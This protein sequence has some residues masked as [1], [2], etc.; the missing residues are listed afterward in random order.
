MWGEIVEHDDVPWPQPLKDFP[1][2]IVNITISAIQG[3]AAE[4]D[5]KEIFPGQHS[6]QPGVGDPCR[7]TEN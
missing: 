7:R 6:F 2:Q 4:V 3:S 1:G 5:G